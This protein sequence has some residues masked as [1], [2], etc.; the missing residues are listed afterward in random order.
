ME[1][2][3]KTLSGCAL[4]LSFVSVS[5]TLFNIFQRESR[6]TELTESSKIFA[7]E[8]PKETLPI[9]LTV[10]ADSIQEPQVERAIP[11]L[12]VTEAP[13]FSGKCIQ[14]STKYQWRCFKEC[15]DA[16]MREHLSISG[17]ICVKGT[18]RLTL[19]VGTDGVVRV[20]KMQLPEDFL[21]AEIHRVIVKIPIL[22]PAQKD[23]KVVS[24]VCP[25]NYEIG[26]LAN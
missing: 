6:V 21:T 14:V 2:S 22:R 23:G 4:L 16:F 3:N 13:A 11:Y 10:R 19:C 18:I 12:L 17:D 7:Y 9:A 8:P 5:I 1:S 20:I 25:Y 24:V 26:K 15:M